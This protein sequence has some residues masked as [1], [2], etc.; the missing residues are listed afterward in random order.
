MQPE[1]PDLA[2]EISI[3]NVSY[4]AASQG[5]RLENVIPEIKYN[6]SYW[7]TEPDVARHDQQKLLPSVRKLAVSI[8]SLTPP[9]SNNL[10]VA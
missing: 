7:R 5:G 8:A 2:L 10:V 3:R 1:I 4:G 6:V 9:F